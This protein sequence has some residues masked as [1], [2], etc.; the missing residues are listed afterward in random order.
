M[1]VSRGGGRGRR[2]VGTRKGDGRVAVGLFCISRARAEHL[3][4]KILNPRRLRHIAYLRPPLAAGRGTEEE[5]DRER[6]KEAIRESGK[7]FGSYCT[8]FPPSEEGGGYGEAALRRA[9]S[10]FTFKCKS[11]E[12][13]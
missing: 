7:G 11:A 1:A 8:P 9:L 5:R 12:C 4:C 3:R 13:R 2:E 6:E 10:K